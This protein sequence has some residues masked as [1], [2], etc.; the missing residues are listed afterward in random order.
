MAQI[1]LTVV[2]F[3]HHVSTWKSPFMID[4]LFNQFGSLTL[5]PVGLCVFSPAIGLFST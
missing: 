3:I 1:S 5:W 2:G 4:I